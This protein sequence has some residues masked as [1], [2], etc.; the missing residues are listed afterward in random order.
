MNKQNKT[1]RYRE[2]ISGYQKGKDLEGGQNG[3]NGW[4]GKLYLY[5]SYCSKAQT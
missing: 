3:L 2:Q 4:R 1:H 5:N